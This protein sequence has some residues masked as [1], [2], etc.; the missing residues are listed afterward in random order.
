[1]VEG[2]DS[3][4]D[5]VVD[6]LLPDGPEEELFD[7]TPTQSPKTVDGRQLELELELGSE[8]GLSRCEPTEVVE[9]RDPSDIFSENLDVELEGT[10]METPNPMEYT[11]G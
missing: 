11:T 4:E 7:L 3:D 1:M 6:V 2:N 8:S 9:S 10:Q 5:E